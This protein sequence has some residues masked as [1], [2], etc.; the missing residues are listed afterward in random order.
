MA[1][2]AA[3]ITDRTVVVV[4]SAPAFPHGVIDPIEELSELAREPR[5][6]LPHR[7]LPRRLRAAVGRAPGL[8]VPPFDFR[9]PGVTSMSADTHKFGYAAKGTSVVLYRGA[10][11]RHHQYFTITDWPGGLYCHADVRRQ[12]PRR[13]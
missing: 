12:P 3:A 1:A 11:L 8:R 4:G 9:L 5:R 6:R 2:T 10:E 13:R 7:R